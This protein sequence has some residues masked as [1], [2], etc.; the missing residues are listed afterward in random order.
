MDEFLVFGAGWKRVRVTGYMGKR[1]VVSVQQ[2]EGVMA[3]EDKPKPKDGW[4]KLGL[5]T[6]PM[7]AL[8][9]IGFRFAYAQPQ[10]DAKALQ[11][12][13]VRQVAESQLTLQRLA[14]IQP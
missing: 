9:G 1:A 3:G 11:D 2:A 6:G 12:E 13:N 14:V 4:D 8:A 5:F 10:A 7:C